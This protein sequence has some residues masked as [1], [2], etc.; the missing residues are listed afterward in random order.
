MSFFAAIVFFNLLR[1]NGFLKCWGLLWVI[2][3]CVVITILYD[4][5]YKI[6]VNN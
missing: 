6:H 1:L 4:L 2:C 5:L 3:Y